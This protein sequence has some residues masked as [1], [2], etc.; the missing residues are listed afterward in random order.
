M[1]LSELSWGG[2]ALRLH[3]NGVRWHD[4]H[5]RLL[6]SRTVHSAS[7]DLGVDRRD[8][9]AGVHATVAAAIQQWV[10]ASQG[11][12]TIDVELTDEQLISPQRNLVTFTDPTPFDDGTCNRDVMVACA[13]LN[14][15][16]TNGQMLAASIAFNPYKRHSA[17]GLS[18]TNDIGLV[19]LHEVGHL[20]GLDHTPLPD[21]AMSATA[22]METAGMGIAHYARRQLSSDDALTLRSIYG[23]TTGLS[24]LR[25][26]VLQHGQA[27]PHAHVMALEA[28][29]PAVWS[30][31]TD[32]AGQYEV[33]VRPGDYKLLVEPQDG[34]G[35]VA[36]PSFPT[37]FWTATGGNAR[38]GEVLTV[39][40]D[41]T[42]EGIDFHLPDGPV[43]NLTHIGLRAN[44]R[45]LGYP[46][47]VVARGRSHDLGMGRSPGGIPGSVRIVGEGIETVGDPVMPASGPGF[48]FQKINVAAE[49]RLGAYT[50]QFLTEEAGA[51]MAGAVRIAPNPHVAEALPAEGE[52]GQPF[53]P[54][55]RIVLSGTDLAEGEAEGE[56]W[57]GDAPLP[58]QLA[59]TSVV[60]GDVYAELV[61]VHPERIELVVPPTAGGGQAAIR[62]LTGVGVES[63]LFEVSLTVQ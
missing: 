5:L 14:F 28:G 46:R 53:L 52:A 49:A 16:P 10:R 17:L 15:D 39:G 6:V 48:L 18:Y 63:N 58:T 3:G 21:A 40:E 30:T 7:G 42:R 19:M 54:G 31:Q 11:A 41:E 47:T 51:V 13:V 20:L 59:G 57:T 23:D 45:Y 35:A 36:G 9:A 44:G 34:P 4:P 56:R 1:A 8:T 25:G 37:V 38:E 62:V 12:V 32:G 22:E 26:A 61:S 2:V 24:R 55:Q 27:V 50:A 33:L 29:G 43:L 60:V